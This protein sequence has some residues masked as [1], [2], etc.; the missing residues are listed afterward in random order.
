MPRRGEPRV[1]LAI[2]G[3]ENVATQYFLLL[4]FL[5]LFREVRFAGARLGRVA[6]FVSVA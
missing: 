2:I 1:C 6:I 4:L 5:L 3:G